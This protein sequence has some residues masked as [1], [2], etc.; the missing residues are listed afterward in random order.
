MKKTVLSLVLAT[1][2]TGMAQAA[3]E[4]DVDNSF[5]PYKGGM[6]SAPVSLGSILLFILCCVLQAGGVSGVACACRARRRRQ[7]YHRPGELPDVPDVKSPRR[8][9]L[10]RPGTWAG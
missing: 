2:F 1:A 6:P 10:C 3:T 9:R 5:N 7:K 4:A 8:A